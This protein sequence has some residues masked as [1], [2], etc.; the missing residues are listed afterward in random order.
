[1][2]VLEVTLKNIITALDTAGHAT[3][4]SF[5]NESF[6]KDNSYSVKQIMEHSLEELD[7]CDA[8]FAFINSNERSEGML[9]EIGYAK[10][11]GKPIVLAVREGVGAHSS[12]GVA[13]HLIEFKD[14]EDLCAQAEQ[15]KI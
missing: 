12:K 6:F 13:D 10:A 1:M 2:S 4:C 9:I 14:L 7:R 15:L 3:Y 5:G 8:I 11:K